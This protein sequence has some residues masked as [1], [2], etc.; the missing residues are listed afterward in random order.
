M[1]GIGE[2][3]RISGVST[4]RHQPF[5]PE[6]IDGKTGGGNYLVVLFISL[7]KAQF[8][9]LMFSTEK[10]IHPIEYGNNPVAAPVM[11]PFLK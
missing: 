1:P 7:V 8:L 5:L 4:Y 11:E 6:N 3:I 2:L 10:C 9:K